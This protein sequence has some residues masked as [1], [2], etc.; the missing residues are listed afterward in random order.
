MLEELAELRR[1][2]FLLGR[3]V[4][5]E[6][7]VRY[8]NSVFG[9][10]WSIVPPL[11]QVIVFTFLFRSVLHNPCRNYSAYVLCGLIPWTFLNSSTMDAGQSL[12]ENYLVIRKVY[13]PREVIPLSVVIANFIHFALAW[14]LYFT[15]FFGV[16]RLIGIDLPVKPTLLYFPLI[17]LVLVCFTVGLSLW[18]SAL[19]MFYDDVRFILQTVFQLGFFIVPVVVPADLFRYTRLAQ[20]HPGLYTLYML[21]PITSVIDAYRKT[22]LEPV[23]LGSFQM[24][25]APVELNWTLFAG[26]A[27]IAVFTLVGGYAYF[28]SRKWLFVER[29]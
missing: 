26:A 20:H 23:P 9:F 21:N 17:T 18:V 27:G 2:H 11:L 4:V 16:A 19:S 29:G 1:F 10:V 13:I 15:A 5:R 25:G 7:K 14:A 28:N 3:L 24:K 6:L 22:I 8:V 12:I